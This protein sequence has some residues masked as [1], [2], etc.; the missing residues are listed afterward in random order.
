[1]KPRTLYRVICGLVAMLC[2]VADAYGRLA[3]ENER[4]HRELNA[5]RGRGRQ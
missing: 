4:L 3:R 5:L 1:V 2:D